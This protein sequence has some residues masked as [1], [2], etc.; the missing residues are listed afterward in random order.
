MGDGDNVLPKL[1][2]KNPYSLV[3][4][5]HRMRDDTRHRQGGWTVNLDELAPLELTR[6][7]HF[8]ETRIGVFADLVVLG[9]LSEPDPHDPRV[10]VKIDFIVL[11]HFT[12]LFSRKPN[13]KL[14]LRGW[15]FKSLWD[16]LWFIFT[17][18]PIDHDFLTLLKE[19]L[20]ITQKTIF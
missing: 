4:V 19:H 5:C 18:S 14:A 9:R 10:G 20:F 3:K 8:C 6:F 17:W 16:P 7:D 13:G 2:V 11:C 1:G 15:E 12:L